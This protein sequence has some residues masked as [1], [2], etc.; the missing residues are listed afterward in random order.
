MCSGLRCLFIV[1]MMMTCFTSPYTE[2][3]NVDCDLRI[4]RTAA[5]EARE[6]WRFVGGQ[7][8]IKEGTLDVSVVYCVY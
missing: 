1:L 3:L 4:V 5:W 6:K 2:P 8:G 7:L